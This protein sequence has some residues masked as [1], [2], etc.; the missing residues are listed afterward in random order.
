MNRKMAENER[1]RTAQNSLPCLPKTPIVD[2]LVRD[3][4]TY[5]VARRESADECL[6]LLTVVDTVFPPRAIWLFERTRRHSISQRMRMN[7]DTRP[8]LNIYE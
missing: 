4:I 3:N 6:G 1:T 8:E 5:Y 2:S 7:N